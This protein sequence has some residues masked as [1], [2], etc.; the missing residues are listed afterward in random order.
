MSTRYK[1]REF[2]KAVGAGTAWIALLKL[3]G[4]NPEN[5]RTHRSPPAQTKDAQTFHSRPELSPPTIDVTTQAHD[6]APGYIFIA[7]K[8]GIG[9][10]GPMIIDNL[11]RLVWFSKDRYATDFKRQYYKGKP[12]LTWWEGDVTQAHGVG[13]YVIFDSS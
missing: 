4:C 5:Q 7:P 6:T 9:Q 12:V 2:L 11:G 3:P 1:R 10:D 13:E 8:K